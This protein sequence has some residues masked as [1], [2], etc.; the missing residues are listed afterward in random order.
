MNKFVVDNARVRPQCALVSEVEGGLVERA[1][2][3]IARR[4]E[5]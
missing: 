4:Y 3:K 5:T 1:A 2:D